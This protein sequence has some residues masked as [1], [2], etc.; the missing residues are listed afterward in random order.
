[1]RPYFQRNAAARALTI[2]VLA[3]PGTPTIKACEP[4]NAQTSSW[5]ITSSWPTTTSCKAVRIARTRSANAP[6]CC[7]PKSASLAPT[8]MLLLL[9]QLVG[10]RE[11]AI[12]D[13]HE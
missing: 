5:S 6:T 9:C 4:V 13:G 1:M 10:G 7:W 2:S 8:A 3:K 11:V 12:A